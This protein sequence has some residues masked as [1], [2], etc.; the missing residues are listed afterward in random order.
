LKC[1]GAPSR[2]VAREAFQDDL[3]SMTE[4][5]AAGG[6]TDVE[7]RVTLGHNQSM[8]NGRKHSTAVL[9]TRGSAVLLHI[10]CRHR[11]GEGNADRFK[12]TLAAANLISFACP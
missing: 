12:M 5:T 9:T 1:N 2:W 8:K 3:K 11:D 10:I 6:K 4:I 7:L